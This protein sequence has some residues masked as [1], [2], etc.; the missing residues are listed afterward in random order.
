MSTFT[1]HF[2]IGIDIV[3]TYST[4]ELVLRPINL[5]ALARNTKIV[6]VMDVTRS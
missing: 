3:Q 2:R 5:V 6:F 4:P 1:F